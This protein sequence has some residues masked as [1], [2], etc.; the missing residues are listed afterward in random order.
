MN[1]PTGD[2]GIDRQTAIAM[3][4][5]LF[6]AAFV[7]GTALMEAGR[8]AWTRWRESWVRQIAEA[9]CERCGGAGFINVKTWHGGIEVDNE[10]PCPECGCQHEY[11]NPGLDEPLEC[12]KCG[13]PMP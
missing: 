9:P 4:V 3:L 8:W 11:W 13:E 6:L 10:P 5:I 12:L 1:D 7:V 2:L